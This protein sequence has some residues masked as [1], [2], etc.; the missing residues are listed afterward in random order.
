VR[1]FKQ[2]L[3]DDNGEFEDLSIEKQNG[4]FGFEE[5]LNV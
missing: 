2:I 4:N 1:L 3:I 5:K